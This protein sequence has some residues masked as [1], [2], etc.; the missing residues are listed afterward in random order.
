VREYNVK[1]DVINAIKM[2]NEALIRFVFETCKPTA[3]T[4]S[5]GS[6]TFYESE[7]LF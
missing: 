6:D 5:K 1:E 3:K 7:L 4:G 2:R